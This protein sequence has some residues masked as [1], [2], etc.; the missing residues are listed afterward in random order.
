MKNLNVKDISLE[1]KA[2]T[3][4]AKLNISPVVSIFNKQQ[5]GSYFLGT[6]F[7]DKALQKI[8]IQANAIA[9]EDLGLDKKF[10]GDLIGVC[11]GARGTMTSDTA[12]AVLHKGAAPLFGF[13]KKAKS[14]ESEEELWADIAE[15]KGSFG[16]SYKHSIVQIVDGEFHVRRSKEGGALLDCAHIGDFIFGLSGSALFREP[17]LNA[18]KRYFLREDLLPNYIFHKVEDGVFWLLGAENRLLKSGLTDNKALPT[19]KK[20]PDAPFHASV[21]C[22]TD[23][24]LYG[25]AGRTLFR[26]R[27]NVEN[28]LDELQVIHKWET[29]WPSSLAV[30]EE[31][32]VEGETAKAKLW[33]SVKESAGAS[34]YELNTEKAVDAEELPPIPALTKIY[35]TT[36]VVSIQH[37]SV[38]DEKS[39][40]AVV[41][42]KDSSFAL[43]FFS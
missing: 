41:K 18:D 6:L 26:V 8:K 15:D 23:S 36:D 27:V 22:H 31:T 38:F 34:I 1:I 17:Y 16:F 35:E 10:D 19:T 7:A 4:D 30:V 37:I 28:R 42:K 11:G 24:W 3:K 40:M 21:D 25:L 5:D 33:I 2:S 12:L 13:L 39:K 43:R 14:P 20:L 29:E 32:Q 9:Y